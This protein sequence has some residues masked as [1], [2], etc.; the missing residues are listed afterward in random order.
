MAARDR[1]T[2]TIICECGVKGEA[3]VSEADHPYMRSRDF[4]ID[5]IDPKFEVLRVEENR[6]GSQIRCASCGA[7]I[8][9]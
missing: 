6:T 7:T 3:E 9:L 4:Q 2:K 8:T 5:S 1:Y